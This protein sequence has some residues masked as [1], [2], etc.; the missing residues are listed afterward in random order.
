[1]DER[2][3]FRFARLDDIQGDVLGNALDAMQDEMQDEDMYRRYLASLRD[4]K[5]T[6]RGQLDKPV[7]YKRRNY[8]PA[9][10]RP[11]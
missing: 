1:M 2:F 5:K 6:T 10:L 3:V 4:D 9:N 11:F 8:I 7:I